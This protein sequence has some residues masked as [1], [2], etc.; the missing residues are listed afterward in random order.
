MHPKNQ[1]RSTTGYA[2]GWLADYSGDD[3]EKSAKH[4]HKRKCRR[5]VRRAGKRQIKEELDNLA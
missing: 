3:G 2:F 5:V 4:F 1:I